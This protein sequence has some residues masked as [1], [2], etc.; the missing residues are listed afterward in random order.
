MADDRMGNHEHQ[1]NA[2]MKTDH[3]DKGQNAPSRN[4]NDDQLADKRGNQGKDTGLG[5]GPNQGNT[6]R[7]ELNFEKS[8]G[9][10]HSDRRNT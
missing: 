6:R 9:A 3:S 8:G 5:K 10:G 1:R 2:G 4:R 7:D